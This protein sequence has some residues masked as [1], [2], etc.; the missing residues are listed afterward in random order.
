M[1]LCAFEH[2]GRNGTGLVLGSG[3]R[4]AVLDLAAPKAVDRL[5][6][7]PACLE[8]LIGKGLDALRGLE[9]D[10][11]RGG[12]ELTPLS[13]L[14]LRAPLGSRGKILGVARNFRAGLAELGQEP[15]KAPAWFAKLPNT[16]I[17]PGEAIRLPEAA[18]EVTYE[19]EVGLVIGKTAR[20]VPLDAAAEHIAGFTILNDVS[21]ADLVRGDGNFLRGKNPDTFCP[22]G[23]FFVTADGV[24]DPHNLRITLDCDGERLQDGNTGDM[25]FNM[26]YLIHHLSQVMTLNPGDVIATGTPSGVAAA[27]TPKKWLKPGME[28]RISVDGLG[29]LANPVR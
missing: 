26:F 18:R 10:A 25:V 8:E 3:P 6:F 21:A 22:M 11:A 14:R 15:P 23:P 17:G 24:P 1:K 12:C 7:A 19:A 28:L 13:S 29:E 27:H 2:N 16:V 5:G 20:Q 9:H 4:A